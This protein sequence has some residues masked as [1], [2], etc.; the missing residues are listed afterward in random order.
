MEFTSGATYTLNWLIGEDQDL[1]PVDYILTP[2]RKKISGITFAKFERADTK[3]AQW[4]SH[5]KA[6][7]MAKAEVLADSDTFTS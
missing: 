5:A 3:K 4:L 2:E 6:S 1:F 7:K